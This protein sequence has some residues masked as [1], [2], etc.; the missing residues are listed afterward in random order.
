M[1]SALEVA[2]YIVQKSPLMTTMKLH[3]LL[4]YSYV[5]YAKAADKPLFDEEFEAW[6]NGPVLRTL[7]QVHR[8]Y[9]LAEKQLFTSTYDL[10]EQEQ[11]A[12]EKALSRY[13][14]IESNI[15]SEKFV[16]RNHGC[17]LE[18]DC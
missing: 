11:A 5:E 1:A 18:K 17:V 10:D 12:V 9:Y 13:L 7:Y 6:R 2:T 3:R 15:L 4:Y 8:G 14:D 16:M